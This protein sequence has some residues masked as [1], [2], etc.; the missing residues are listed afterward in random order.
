MRPT[1][2][3]DFKMTKLAFTNSQMETRD[4]SK[5]GA[6]LKSQMSKE[7]TRFFS[8]SILFVLII[9]FSA[10][11]GGSTSSGSSSALPT[12]NVD[13]QML[14]NNTELQK[15]YAAILE[16]LGE[17]V[18][19]VDKIDIQIT[20]PS[21]EGII[22]RQGRP[23]E[24]SITLS[25]LYPKDKNKLFQ[26]SYNN[27]NKWNDGEVKEIQLLTGNPETFRLEDEMFDLSPLTAENLSKIVT[28]AL[29]KYK[30]TTK[31]SYQYAKWINIK[32]GIV[33]VQ[34]YGK[35]AANA[36]EKSEYYYTDLSGVVKK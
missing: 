7:N 34:I 23:D 2:T 17:N 5:N 32:N 33:K 28:A 4:H 20:R 30:D 27:K 35:L 29:E 26:Q 24:F 19:S 12:D 11:G 25:Y 10:C 13:Y 15:V 8:L 3:R 16:K 6:S 21:L 1:R 36:I 31:Y 14:G 22:I 9:V 18:K